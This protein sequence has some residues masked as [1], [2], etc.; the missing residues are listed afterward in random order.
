MP[1]LGSTPKAIDAFRA[2][3]DRLGIGA[4]VRL[5]RAATS[6]LRRQLRRPSRDA[7][8]DDGRTE[9]PGATLAAQ[10]LAGPPR[11][12]YRSPSASRP[13]R[14]RIRAAPGWRSAPASARPRTL[15]RRYRRE[16]TA[17]RR[18]LLITWCNRDTLHL[19]RRGTIRCCR[20]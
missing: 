7:A 20:R 4:T 3:L 16:L 13:S 17:P 14:P 8:G 18:S 15:R 6:T 1:Y 19:I 5:I 9:R 2:E 11:D 10:L 12:P